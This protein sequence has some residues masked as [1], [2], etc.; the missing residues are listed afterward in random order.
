MVTIEI[1]FLLALVV[2]V[3]GFV[4]WRRDVKA[5]RVMRTTA[6]GPVTVIRDRF[7]SRA[8]TPPAPEAGAS[9]PPVPPAR[10]QNADP[11]EGGD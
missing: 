6:R 7:A 8:A 10:A 1:F 11:G 4:V 2:V 5:G 9:A 3:I